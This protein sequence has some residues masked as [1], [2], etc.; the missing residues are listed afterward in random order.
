MV[1]MVGGQR[2]SKM[3]LMH[4]LMMPQREYCKQINIICASTMLDVQLP[5]CG[6]VR[7]MICGND[8]QCMWNKYI[9]NNIYYEP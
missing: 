1:S 8:M 9:T 2:E 7:Y 3:W 6:G 4:S 5:F